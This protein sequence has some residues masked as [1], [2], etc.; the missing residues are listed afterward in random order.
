MP[1]PEKIY[2]PEPADPSRNHFYISLIKS[3]I[4][5][6]ASGSLVYAGYKLQVLEVIGTA[7]MIAGIGL[8]VAELLGI[9]EEL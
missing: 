7:V 5:L 8:F 9:A 3:I 6:V 4:R 1:I 2:I